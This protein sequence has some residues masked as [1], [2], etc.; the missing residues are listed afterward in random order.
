ML[1][2][3]TR[4]SLSVYRFQ[5]ILTWLSR[6]S[7]VSVGLERGGVSQTSGRIEWAVERAARRVPGAQHCLTQALVAKLLLAR[8]GVPTELRIG[9][10]KGPSGPLKA[11]AWLE[12][13][14]VAVF[15]V[16]ATGLQEYTQLPRLDS[17]PW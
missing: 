5:T 12:S 9:V 8:R 1:L 16:P 7:A 13:G 11:H 2:A 6:W 14:G 3:V 17:T 15:G 4:V 10:T